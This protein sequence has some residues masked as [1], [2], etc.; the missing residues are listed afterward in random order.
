MAIELA[1]VVKL[2]T[3]TSMGTWGGHGA[4][5]FE[6]TIDTDKLKIYPA[7]NQQY[8]VAGRFGSYARALTWANAVGEALGLDV[9]NEVPEEHRS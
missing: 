1:S 3:W 2:T 5:H 9:I 8:D 7:S 4:R 6:I